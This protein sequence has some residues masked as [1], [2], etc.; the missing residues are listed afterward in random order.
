MQRSHPYSAMLL[1]AVAGWA[2]GWG[3]TW[4][5][6]LNLH[7]WLSAVPRDVQRGAVAISRERRP[8]RLSLAA[9]NQGVGKGGVKKCVGASCGVMQRRAGGLGKP[10]DPQG[11]PW[12]SGSGYRKG[13][14]GT[15]QREW[16]QEGRREAG[17]LRCPSALLTGHD[18]PGLTGFALAA[19][20]P[21]FHT[22]SALAPRPH[23]VHTPSAPHPVCT[24]HSAR[25]GRLVRQSST[26]D[27]CTHRRAADTRGRHAGAERHV[28]AI[29][30]WP[31]GDCG[32][33][34]FQSH[35][36]A[37]SD[38]PSGGGYTRASCCDATIAC[39]R[40]AG[41]RAELSRC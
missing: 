28:P 38:W 34:L 8:R 29:A 7:F 25:S 14:G 26:G 13:G 20:V 22:L 27:A 37:T 6:H 35:V 4:V 5:Q 32:G 2:H 3:V 39:R 1:G 41:G 33:D 19:P 31:A 17:G 9:G 12:T 40:H 21:L 23:P 15:D 10:M 11:S 36:T 24:P 30:G 16:Q 18:P